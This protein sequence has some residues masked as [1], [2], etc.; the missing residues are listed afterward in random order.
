MA[1]DHYYNDLRTRVQRAYAE[2]HQQI[3]RVSTDDEDGMLE[4]IHDSDLVLI[5]SMGSQ[6]RFMASSDHLPHQ[7]QKRLDSSLAVIH[8]P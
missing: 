8:F 7:L 1:T 5:P 2:K 4:E 3:L 6:N